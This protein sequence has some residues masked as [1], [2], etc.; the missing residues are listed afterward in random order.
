MGLT[1]RELCANRQEGCA[2]LLPPATPLPWYVITVKPQ[3]EQTV[4]Y[5]LAQKG[6]E[7]FAPTYWAARRWSDRLKRLQLPLFPGYVFCHLGFGVRLSI[8][9]TPGVRSIVSFGTEI[10][11]VPNEDIDRIRRMVTSGCSIEPWPFLK[12]GQRVR[13]H[14]GPLTGLEGILAEF[15]NTWRVV[16]GLELLQRSEAVQLSPDQITPL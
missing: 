12:V 11:P 7:I 5:G 4:Q 3:H 8:L 1:E 2:P 15:R 9:R 13:V 16:V 14:C 6:Y 10:I